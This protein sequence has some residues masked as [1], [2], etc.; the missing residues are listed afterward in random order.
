[1]NSK[2]E[3]IIN[4]IKDM[5][6]K[7]NKNAKEGQAVLMHLA[8]VEALI[9]ESTYQS[10]KIDFT[11]IHQAILHI[12][13]IKIN[14]N[15]SFFGNKLKTMADVMA[16]KGEIILPEHERVLAV[17]T[18]LPFE[19]IPA[20]KEHDFGS[21]HQALVELI[22][23][24]YQFLKNDE[25]RK[26]IKK[27]AK[28]VWSCEYPSD[29]NNQILNQAIGEWQELC[30]GLN[31]DPKKAC[32][33]FTRNI[34]IR[35]LTATDHKDVEDLIDYLLVASNYSENHQDLLKIW[36]QANGGQDINRFLDLLMASGEFTAGNPVG[37]SGVK[38]IEQGWILEKNKVIFSYE[39]MVYSLIKDGNVVANDN[40][41]RLTTVIDPEKIQDSKTN[42]FKVPPLMKVSAKIELT[43]ANN[44]II[45]AIKSLQV[46]SYT[47]DIKK[48][49]FT[50]NEVKKMS[51]N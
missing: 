3:N 2:L 6:S 38:A 39:T 9:I 21:I 13:T 18:T 5:K 25:I 27:S 12:E 46:I 51:Y 10:N 29:E 42:Y 7:L 41:N 23:S 32:K 26:S 40:K 22:S 8:R 4:H 30:M 11:K 31:N 16:E 47:N 19:A 48:P 50:L 44:Q 24:H 14:L 34:S 17:G 35:G 45:P 28:D 37:L 49:D 33:D 15:S 43:I 1:M 20:N 36:L